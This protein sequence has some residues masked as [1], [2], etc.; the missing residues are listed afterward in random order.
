MSVFLRKF[1]TLFTSICLGF[2]SSIALTLTAQAEDLAEEAL[3]ITPVSFTD[4]SEENYHYIP[5]LA[6]AEEGIINGYEDGTFK[7][8][9]TVNRAEALKI[10]LEAFNT[11]PAEY[12]NLDEN[13][14]KDTAKN[15]WYAS[16][17][18]YAKDQEIITG[19]NDDEFEPWKTINLA[20][21]LKILEESLPNYLP[22]P[23]T[24]DPFVDVTMNDWH[25]DYLQYAKNREM[26][27][28]SASGKVY[29]GQEMTRGYLAEVIYKLKNFGKYSFGKGTF[30]GTAFDGRGT[31]SGDTFDMTA[32]TAAHKT[33]PFDSIVEVTN[34][35]NGKSLQVRINDRGPYG[36]GRVIDLSQAAFEKIAGLHRGII[37]VQYRV[38]E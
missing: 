4:V 38:I 24:E 5:I 18:A 33:L 23:A 28:I 30:Y 20:E 10:I 35:A 8:Y 1:F 25:V 27:N 13:P 37:N 36:H 12:D 32:M 14:F 2:S 29:P 26:V 19:Y 9:E 15:S 21:S 31:A 6:L 3:P 11:P 16:Y 22:N 34:M 17:I 7:P